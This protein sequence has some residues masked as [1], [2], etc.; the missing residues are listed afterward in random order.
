[1]KNLSHI[2]HC[3]LPGIDHV[4]VGMHACHFYSTREQL[5]AALVPYI[6]AGL[7]NN[8]RCLWI[9]APPL[10]AHEAI[11]ALRAESESVDDAFTAGALRILNFDQWYQRSGEWR[12]LDV[13]QMWLDAEESA[14]AEGY[15]GL[16]ITGNTS[17][18]QPSGWSTFM[19][20]EEALTERFKGRRIITLCSYALA[21]C[22]E[23]HLSEVFHAHHCALE[24]A[25]PVWEVL[26]RAGYDLMN[27]EDPSSGD[28]NRDVTAALQPDQAGLFPADS[29][30]IDATIN[31]Y[32]CYFTD[33]DDRIQTYEQIE[34]GDDAGAVLKAQE[35][36]TGSRSLRPNSGRANG[37]SGNGAIRFAGDRRAR[38]A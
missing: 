19:E 18:L 22:D 30:R 28:H 36:L 25:S 8:E 1:M 12:G 21:Q 31:S 11:E 16:R 3:G 10:P 13:M 7:R 23:R 17:F 32:R 33:V 14:L 27:W 4:P 37:S 35:L 15:N 6:S 9:T 34:C 24:R 38:R 5:V 29:S 26:P 2:T 20:Y